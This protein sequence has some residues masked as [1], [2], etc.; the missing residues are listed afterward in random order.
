MKLQRCTLSAVLGLSLALLVNASPRASA[1]VT[2]TVSWLTFEM[3]DIYDGSGTTVL[4]PA[5]LP[6]YPWAYYYSWGYAS[7]PAVNPLYDNYY[8]YPSENP[9]NTAVMITF[10]TTAYSPVPSGGGFGQGVGAVMPA[11]NNTEVTMST[12]RADYIVSFDARAEGML[13]ESQTVSAEM[14]I[15]MDAPDDTIQP[16]DADSGADRII[17]VGKTVAIGSNWT[18]FVYRLDDANVDTGTPEKNLNLYGNLINSVNYNLNV[19]MPSDSFGFDYANY[20]YLDN[21]KLEVINNTNPP[22]PTPPSFGVTMAEWNFDDKDLWYTYNGAYN[23]SANSTLPIFTEDRHAAG[24][25]TG[26]SN[27]W[28]LAMDNSSLAVDTPAWAGGGM[29]GGGPVDFSL[30]NTPNLA[31]YRLSFDARVQGLADGKMFTTCAL[32]LFFDSPDDTIQPPDADTDGDTLARLDFPLTAVETNWQTYTYTLNKGS[33]GLG[34]TANFAGYFSKISGLRTQWQ[35]ENA[36]SVADWGFDADNAL[37]ID[38]FKL[39]R[40]YQSLP[41]LSIN[42]SGSEATITWGAWA[43]QGHAQLE[44]ANGLQSAY[45]EVPGATTSPARVSIGTGPS[46]FRLKWVA[47]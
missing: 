28:V 26:G 12:N 47:P 25:G 29:G 41:P 1:Q 24:W 45:S 21:V 23:W 4:I 11:F 44:R 15:Q 19:H 27:A 32:Q 33:V 2:N 10:D 31:E 22:P 14:Q 20:I 17:A 6:R 30:F 5:G 34:S 38:N 9:T 40:V 46:F 37:A 7:D 36:A 35:I 39:E 13:P 43:G 3:M 18:H 8:M 16:P 42:V